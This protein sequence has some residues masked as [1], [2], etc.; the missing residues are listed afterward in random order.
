MWLRACPSGDDLSLAPVASTLRVAEYSFSSVSSRLPPGEPDA[1]LLGEEATPKENATTCD[2]ATTPYLH[3]LLTKA[4][5]LGRNCLKG[6]DGDRANAV[7]AAAG[8]NFDPLLRRF[9]VLSRAL[10]ALLSRLIPTTQS[11]LNQSALAF[12]MTTP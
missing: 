12:F 6:R 7:R 4:T 1:T 8:Y 10:F 3:S 2:R 11:T 5:N 9:K